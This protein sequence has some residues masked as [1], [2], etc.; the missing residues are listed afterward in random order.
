MEERRKPRRYRMD[1]EGRMRRTWD[2]RLPEEMDARGMLLFAAETD[3]ALYGMLTVDTLAVIREAGWRYEDGEPLSLDELAAQAGPGD[4]G[5]Y[6]AVYRLSLGE[7]D[8]RGETEQYWASLA[9]DSAC[10]LSITSALTVDAGKGGTMAGR[11]ERIMGEWGR[12]R[13]EWI[14]ANSIA[15]KKDDGQISGE[16]RRWAA[17]F[18]VPRNDP[19]GGSLWRSC[20]ADVPAGLLEQAASFVRKERTPD[21]KGQDKKGRKASILKQLAGGYPGDRRPAEHVADRG[22]GQER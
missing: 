6:P 5:K 14:L 21:R 11:L 2:G 15:Q 13:V 7:A 3:M 10:R 9:Q 12:D 16:N 17:S 20:V 1:G 19:V 4:G 22:M 8:E 18:H